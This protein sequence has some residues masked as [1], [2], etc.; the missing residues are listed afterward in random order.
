MAAAPVCPVMIIIISVF[1][2]SHPNIQV[3]CTAEGGVGVGV[4]F[5]FLPDLWLSYFYCFEVCG[6]LVMSRV[7]KLTYQ[8]VTT[9]RRHQTGLVPYPVLSIS[10]CLLSDTQEFYGC[11]KSSVFV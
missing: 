6:T 1:N 9:K 4:I 7:F 11:A 5:L 8:W 3:P 10:W 2:R